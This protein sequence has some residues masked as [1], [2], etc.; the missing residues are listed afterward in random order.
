[1]L[2]ALQP[3]TCFGQVPIKIYKLLRSGVVPGLLK[4]FAAKGRQRRWRLL[5]E[6]RKCVPGSNSEIHNK[7]EL[8]SR[9]FCEERRRQTLI[10]IS[11]CLCLCGK[12]TSVGNYI[13]Y[14]CHIVLFIS[15]FKS[16]RL[17]VVFYSD[18]TNNAI[19]SLILSAR[20]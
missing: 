6:S 13:T 2:N 9:M 8:S 3:S 12:Y 7:C 17:L 1:M 4:I 18:H 5:D 11:L 16:K 20:A 15:Y 14:I 10:L 19:V